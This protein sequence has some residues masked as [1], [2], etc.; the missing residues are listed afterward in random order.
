L[1]ENENVHLVAG[2]GHGPAETFEATFEASVVRMVK[3]QDPHRSGH[4]R[5]RRYSRAG[6]G[7]EP[8]GQPPGVAGW[9][10]GLDPY[11]LQGGG[12]VGPFIQPFALVHVPPD[13]AVTTQSRFRLS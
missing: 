6:T 8:V 3:E 1:T 2:I 10:A 11:L 5:Q 12:T 13:G 7:P 4:P 9:T